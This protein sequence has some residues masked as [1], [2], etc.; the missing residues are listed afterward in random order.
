[1]TRTNRSFLGSML[2]LILWMTCAPAFCSMS[3]TIV[4]TEI[5]FVEEENEQNQRTGEVYYLN[6]ED[7]HHV[8][9]TIENHTEKVTIFSNSRYIAS[10]QAIP[11][12]PPEK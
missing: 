1:M 11:V 8:H 10:A 4:Q 3:D 12:P 7:K 5:D 2:L 6:K 9:M